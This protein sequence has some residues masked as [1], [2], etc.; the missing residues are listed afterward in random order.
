MPK[1]MCPDCYTTNDMQAPRCKNCGK[2]LAGR[3][4]SKRRSFIIALSLVTAVVLSSVIVVARP[5]IVQLFVGNNQ[6]PAPTRIATPFSPTP[7]ATPTK[8]LTVTYPPL[9]NGLG[10]VT[11]SLGNN[12]GVN[13]GSSAPANTG[14]STQALKLQAAQQLRAGNPESA[15]ALW[16]HALQTQSNDAETLIYLEDQRVMDSEKPYL[17]LVAATAFTPPLPDNQYEG[18]LQGIYVAQYAFNQGIHPFQVRILVA[19]TGSDANV[20]STADVAQQIVRIAHQDPT[21]MGV[22]GWL[23]SSNTL[24]AVRIFTKAKIPLISPQA[25]SDSLTGISSYFSRIVSSNKMQAQAAAQFMRT[26]LKVTN[27]VVFVDP[28]E[29]YSQNLA[30]DFEGQFASDGGHLHEITF[31]TDATN[32]FAPLIA[33]A[34]KYH[35]DAFYFT[36]SSTGDAGLFQDALPT[37]GAGATIP[38]FGG[39]GGEISH[40]HGY[41]RW[42]FTEY[43]FHGEHEELPQA[44]QF[45]QMY[46]DDFDPSPHLPPDD[47][48]ILSY[49]TASVVLTA[50]QAVYGDGK[51]LLIPNDLKNELAKITGANAFQGVSGQIAF[52]SDG[53]PINKAVVILFASTGGPIQLKLVSGCFIKGCP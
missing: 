33:A 27:P 7:N 20:A 25:S 13:D 28:S 16:K 8:I 44:K 21:I 6:G 38:A 31:K 53:D 2:I 40:P 49:D 23:N 51:T 35:P 24:N 4:Q 29:A 3:G 12:I 26:T 47:H 17:T 30:Q 42:Y 36:S 37:S 34:L 45:I 46:N 48:A 9:P 19:N 32:N 43:A 50:L 14:F 5:R 1:Q 39:D 52:G 41:G 18:E 10:E 11:D 22:I 15:I